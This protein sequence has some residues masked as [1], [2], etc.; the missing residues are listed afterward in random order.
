MQ[1]MMLEDMATRMEGVSEKMENINKKM[2]VTLRRVARGGDKLC[3]DI[4][5]VVLALGLFS[6]AWKEFGIKDYLDV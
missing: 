6:V 5:C 3:V 1:N 4:F 2:K